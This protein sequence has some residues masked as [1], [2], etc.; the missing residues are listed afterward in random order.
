M[1]EFKPYLTN[2]GSIGLYNEDFNDIYHS[3]TGAIT[4][5]YEKFI[6]PVNFELLLSKPKINVLDICYGIGY[7]SKCFLNYIFENFLKDKNFKSKQYY[8]AIYT[9]NISHVK[10]NLCSDTIHTDNLTNKYTNNERLYNIDSIYDNNICS[11]I[12]VTAIDND[13][14]L[15]FLSPFIK[16][17]IK[18]FSN[19]KLEFKYERIEKYINEKNNKKSKLKINKLINFLI[20]QKI[21]QN[22]PEILENTDILSILERKEYLP[23]FDDDIKGIYKLDKY[24]RCNKSQIEYKLPFLHNIYYSHISNKY[25]K[26]LKRYNLQDINFELKIDDARN[27]IKNDKTIY[28][29]IF[30]DAFSPS[31]CPCLW[32]LEFFQQLHKHLDKDG[33]ILTYSTSAAIRNAMINAGLKIGYIYNKDKNFP[34][35]TVAVKNSN[36]IKYHLSEYDLGLLKTRAGIFYRDENLTGLNEAIIERRNLEINNSNLMSS[37]KYNKL[38]R[39]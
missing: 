3:A 25:K 9:N 29:L 21:A 19:N 31:K 1:Y 37:S 15:T 6:L 38:H 13:K 36:L 14:N 8:S 27:F 28:N 16:T 22:Y 33:V 4:E 12:S 20:Y 24:K 11:N 7:N 35:G 26:G 23:I 39:V 17:D 34:I 10:N 30:L 5:A 2:D 18:N 32:T